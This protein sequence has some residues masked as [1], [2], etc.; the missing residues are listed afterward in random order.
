MKIK[1]SENY[2]WN[3][4]TLTETDV[5]DLHETLDQISGP[6]SSTG[7]IKD[8]VIFQILVNICKIL[9]FKCNKCDKT[10]CPKDLQNQPNSCLSC[11]G[12]VCPDCSRGCK[13]SVC[14]PCSEIFRQRLGIPV[15]YYKLSHQKKITN[16]VV[17]LV[18]LSS[19]TF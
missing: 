15:E 9:P 8:G 7:L 18:Y 19:R 13:I 11:N 10:V 5:K 4:K 6:G 1:I 17:S 3:V 2:D 16:S 14:D 12:S